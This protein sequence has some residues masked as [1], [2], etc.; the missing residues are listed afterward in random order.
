MKLLSGKRIGQ[1]GYELILAV[2]FSFFIHAAIVAVALFLY[3]V[4]SPK[5]SVPPFYSVKLVG[6]P[7]ESAP[8]P[9]H[10]TAPLPPPTPEEEKKT[11]PKKTI[12]AAPKAATPAAKKSAMPEIS[13]QKQKQKQKPEEI[14]PSETSE[15]QSQKTTS[16]TESSPVS[17]PVAVSQPVAAQKEFKYDYYLAQVKDRIRGNWNPPPVAKDAK[18]RVIFAINRSGRIID[19]NIDMDHSKGTPMFIQAAQRAIMSSTFPEL[20]EDYGKQTVEFSVDLMAAE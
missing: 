16:K 6:L 15:A 10:Q 19:V 7:A 12:K 9:V 20:P 1:S 8:T 13:E 17:P 18:V 11:E 4:A 5:V 14:K 2:F 3:V